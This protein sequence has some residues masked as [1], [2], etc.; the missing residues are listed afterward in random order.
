MPRRLLIFV[1]LAVVAAAGCVRLG[2]WQL[3]RRAERRALNELLRARLDAAPVDISALPRDT[4]SRFRRAHVSGTPDYEH[5]LVLTIRS[6][7]GSPGLDLVTPLRRAGSDT[8]ILVNRGW[9]YAPDGI[10]VDLARWRERDS[11][12]VGYVE[13]LT[14][15]RPDA[16]DAALHDRPRFLRRLEREAVARALPY[17][18]SPLVLV[19]LAPKGST[20]RADQVARLELPS[21]DEGPHLGYAFQ[22]FSFA[23]IAVAGSAVVVARERSSRDGVV[24]VIPLK[25]L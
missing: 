18:V 19:A 22:W 24:G 20:P 10:T 9:V 4:S 16:P 6:H 17:P 8:A 2:F 23:A 1:F 15:H 21:L 25:K 7:Q 3:S 13:V 11:V 14:P 5:E 12:Y